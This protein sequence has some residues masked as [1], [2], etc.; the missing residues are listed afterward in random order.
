M[1]ER[2]NAELK[3]KVEWFG[4]RTHVGFNGTTEF[5][6]GSWLKKI[7]KL[8]WGAIG[9]WFWIG[10]EKNLLDGLDIGWNDSYPC[11]NFLKQKYIHIPM[12]TRAQTL[13]LCTSENT[14]QTVDKPF[15]SAYLPLLQKVN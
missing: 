7:R 8:I 3:G 6:N 12:L 13:F 9:L 15:F 5:K 10:L 2:G 4:Q 11:I 14:F 1:N